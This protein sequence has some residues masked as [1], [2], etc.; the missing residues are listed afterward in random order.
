[1]SCIAEATAGE[2]IRE[3]RV[4][5]DMRV[6]LVVPWERQAI[7]LFLSCFGFGRGGGGGGGEG[8]T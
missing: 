7:F 8:E 5:E 6:A 2:V 1:M 3:L 4:S